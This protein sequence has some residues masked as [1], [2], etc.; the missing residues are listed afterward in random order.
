MSA[1]ALDPAAPAAVDR[2]VTGCWPVAAQVLREAGCELVFGLPA[3]E[4]GLLDAAAHTDGLTPIPVRDQR[5]GACAA[6]A[7]AMLTRRPVVLAL[8]TGP[9]FTNALT[10]L[11]EGNSLGAPVIVV[12]TRIAAAEIGRGGFQETDQRSLAQS[13]VKDHL[14]VATA[15]SLP[16]ALRRAAHLALNGRPA[17]VLVE[18]TTEVG[19]AT[20]LIVHPGAGDPVQVARSAPDPADVSVAAAVL[21]RASRPLL[22]AGGGVR[23][24]GATAAVRALAAE[25][26][27]ATATTASGR[28]TFDERHPHYLGLVG[29]YATPPLTERIAEADVVL[30][31][32][33]AL[34]E[35]VRMGWDLDR[36][37]LVHADGDPAAFHRSVPAEVTLLGDA[38]LTAAALRAALAGDAGAARRTGWLGSVVRARQAMDARAAAVTFAESPTRTVLRALVERFPDAVLVQENGLH[39]IWGYHLSALTLPAD[40]PLVGPGEQTMM[41]FGLPAAVGASVARPGRPV[42]VVCGDGAF[43]MSSNTLPT[44]AELGCPLVMV[45]FDNGGFGWPRFLRQQEGEP[46]TTADFGTRLPMAEL[47]EALGGVVATVTDAESAGSALRDARA[48]VDDGRLALVVVPVD[49]DDV[50]V[51]IR[52]ICGVEGPAPW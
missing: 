48:A 35:T 42:V 12:T 46:T 51:G 21:A 6:V 7:A 8:T 27:A 41:G 37:R 22:L 36:V 38:G 5:A 2:A 13:V 15:E 52:R 1:P 10:G 23:A 45:V 31:I 24:A 25:W 30:A 26:G 34:E 9:A 50:P 28:G 44:A 40:F 43:A 11:L 39:D 33:T 20:D 18:I 32:G 4:P 19:T 16:W 17:P 3:D 29:L 14:V 49:D 47:V